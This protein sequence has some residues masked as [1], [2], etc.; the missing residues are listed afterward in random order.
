MGYRC[1]KPLS[2]CVVTVASCHLNHIIDSIAIKIMTD[3]IRIK[4]AAWHYKQ[5]DSTVSEVEVEFDDN[6]VGHA[7][8]I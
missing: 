5:R 8:S 7:M 6:G 4:P 3:H 2:S 1:I